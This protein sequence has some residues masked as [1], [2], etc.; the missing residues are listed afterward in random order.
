M[1]KRQFPIRRLPDGRA[2]LNLGSSTRCAP[3]WN[4][5]DFSWI[6]RLGRH[7]RLCRMLHRYGLLTSARYERIRALDPHTIVWDLRRGIPFP[8]GSFDVVYHSHLL[9]HID[10]DSAVH[11]LRECRRVLA[12]DGVLRVVVP[13]LEWLTRGYLDRLEQYPAVPAAEVEAAA[14]AIFDQMIIRT[15]AVRREQ[16]RIVRLLESVLIGDTGR[17]GTAHRWMYDR[18]S[19]AELLRRAGLEPIGTRT[20][21]DSVIAGWDSFMLDNEPD[22]S[23]YK[24]ESMYMEARP[25]AVDAA[26]LV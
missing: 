17:N 4:N 16:K 9:E 18:V 14:A 3:G 1:M 10:R 5:I 22:G 12:P 20:H 8:G 26:V 11:F 2:C 6:I 15:P 23:A 24:P 13:D 21:R 25:M 19:L 7:P